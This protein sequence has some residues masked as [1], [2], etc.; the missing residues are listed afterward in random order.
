[1]RTFLLPSLVFIMSLINVRA[2]TYMDTHDPTEIKSLLSKENELAGFGG[3]DLKVGD[4]LN[5]RSLLT[6]AYGGLLVNGT[7]MLGIAG[8]GLVTDVEFDGII[9][10]TSEPKTLNLHMG[11]AGV[12]LGATILRREMIHLSVPVLFGAGS[13][14]VSDQQ[15]FGTNLGS[16]T[17]FTIESSVFF[18]V[19]P[20]LQLEFNITKSFRIAAGANYRWVQGSDLRNIE[21]DQLRDWISTVSFRFGK[22]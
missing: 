8:Y 13:I 1:M 21:D 2:Q 7:Y 15:F 12:M 14:D 22:F 5:T 4:L 20:G 11:Y 19:E 3:I 18:V 10:E 17:D 16:D 9:S 6:G